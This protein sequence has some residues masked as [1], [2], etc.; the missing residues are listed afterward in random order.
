[1]F[2]NKS[3]P[4][5]AQVTRA[6]TL[7][8]L[9]VVM[10][11]ISL[12]ASMLLPSLTRARELGRRTKCISN[13][14]EIYHCT[15][16]YW[17]DYDEY[18]PHY[19]DPNEPAPMNE[20]NWKLSQYIY[21]D[22]DTQPSTGG[23]I[24]NYRKGIFSCPSSRRTHDLGYGLN[25]NLALKRLPYFNRQETETV[26]VGEPTGENDGETAVHAIAEPD[27][28]EYKSAASLVDMRRHGNGAN[29]IFLD[30]HCI[31]SPTALPLVHKSRST[32]QR[33]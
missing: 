17:M 21:Y 11:V 25:V 6:F 23:F 4:Q 5:S 19:L 31:W 30:G 33:P 8:E 26:L 20:W 10:S 28:P 27:S 13:M 14:R 3:S 15:M 16:F 24:G 9:L 22:V 32:Y 2:Q 7:I 12:L 18:F 29:Y 1:M